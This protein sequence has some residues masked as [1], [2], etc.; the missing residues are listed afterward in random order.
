MNLDNKS[1]SILTNTREKYMKK[2]FESSAEASLMYLEGMQWVLSYYTLKVPDWE[3]SYKYDYAP[4]LTSIIEAM[5]CKLGGR[6]KRG[7]SKKK[8]ININYFL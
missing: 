3:G 8:I 1:A 7:A 6:E 5:S 4:N 2:H